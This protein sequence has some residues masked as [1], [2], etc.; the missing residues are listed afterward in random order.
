MEDGFRCQ[1][2]VPKHGR[3]FSFDRA[4][5]PPKPAVRLPRQ[6]IKSWMFF[7]FFVVLVVVASGFSQATRGR[8]RKESS[9]R[10]AA[11]KLGVPNQKMTLWA[12]CLVLPAKAT[13]NTP[14]RAKS[15]SVSCSV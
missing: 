9:Y 15:C 5:A 7:C 3:N 8:F 12:F 11:K 2:N 13:D 4:F 10:R 6:F 14:P 1:G